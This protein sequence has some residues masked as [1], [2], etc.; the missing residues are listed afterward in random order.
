MWNH[1][2]YTWNPHVNP[3]VTHIEDLLDYF[4]VYIYV[5]MAM[6]RRRQSRNLRFRRQRRW[7]ICNDIT[8]CVADVCWDVCAFE[9]KDMKYSRTLLLII[10]IS[11][12][13]YLLVETNSISISDIFL[14]LLGGPYPVK[15]FCSVMHNF[16][17]FSPVLWHYRRH[18][19]YRRISCTIMQH[20][21]TL[22]AN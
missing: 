3:K 15:L 8:I 12:R 7:N 21:A 1:V 5:P 6:K 17:H 11:Y 4:F 18:V 13:A 16:C 20:Y 19:I 9:L 14:F 22:Y 10:S 2:K